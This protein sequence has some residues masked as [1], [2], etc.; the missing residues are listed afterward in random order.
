MCLYLCC[1]IAQVKAIREL[2]VGDKLTAKTAAEVAQRHAWHTQLA[3]LMN[4]DLVKEVGI[5]DRKCSM[6]LGRRIVFA[7]R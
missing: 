1:E 4:A 6:A 5:G 7:K 2:M 3:V